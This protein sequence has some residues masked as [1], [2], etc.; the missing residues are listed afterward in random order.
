MIEIEQEGSGL[1][2]DNSEY[3]DKNPNSPDF[4]GV[5]NIGGEQYR[6]AMWEK[7]FKNG[8]G[9]SLSIQPA[10][11]TFSDDD[12]EDEDEEPTPRKARRTTPARKAPAKK[13]GASKAPFRKP[14]R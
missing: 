1:V 2:F 14:R 5:A 8:Y 12:D 10:E 9:Y 4:T 13:G 3:K 6:V 11:A 7:E